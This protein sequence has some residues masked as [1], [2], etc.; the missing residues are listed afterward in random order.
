MG[1]QGR[2]LRDECCEGA[3]HRAGSL[4]KGIPGRWNSRCRSPETRMFS[5]KNKAH[6]T[7]AEGV[8]GEKQRGEVVREEA[9]GQSMPGGKM[10]GNHRRVLSRTCHGKDAYNGHRYPFST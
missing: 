1:R 3:G 9:G 2:L 4:G 8:R 5:R 6:V 10:V 7:G